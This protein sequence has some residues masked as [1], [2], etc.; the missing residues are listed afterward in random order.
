METANL[1]DHGVA[2]RCCGHVRVSGG[3]VSSRIDNWLA[4]G[5]VLSFCTRICRVLVLWRG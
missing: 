4:L 2:S 1:V 3:D 5:W